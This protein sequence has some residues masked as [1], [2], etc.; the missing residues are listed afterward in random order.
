MEK[1][2]FSKFMFMFRIRFPL[3]K[4]KETVTMKFM[5]MF[6]IRFPLLKHKEKVTMKFMFMFRMKKFKKNRFFYST[7]T[8]ESKW[9]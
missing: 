3:L 6:R 5:F 1:S 2:I 9:F 4:H 7:L 8:A